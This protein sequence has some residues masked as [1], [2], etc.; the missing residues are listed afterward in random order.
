M[1][2][3]VWEFGNEA[4][5]DLGMRVWEWSSSGLGSVQSTKQTS[6]VRTQKTAKC[7]Y[8]CQCKYPRIY[9]QPIHNATDILYTCVY[10]A[11]GSTRMGLS[12]LTI[13]LTILEGKRWFGL[14]DY[15][16]MLTYAH[17]YK[18]NVSKSIPVLQTQER[19]SLRIKLCLRA[20]DRNLEDPGSNTGWISMTFF[21]IHVSNLKL[22][23]ENLLVDV[24]Q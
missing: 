21:A 1:R 4:P 20:S 16:G 11:S 5:C 9:T 24:T 19:S 3:W 7:W 14:I 6:W 10:H 12:N 22:F 23:T 13:S 8:P 18:M 15:T 2:V 17:V